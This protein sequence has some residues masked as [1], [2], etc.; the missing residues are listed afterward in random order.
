MLPLF[1]ALFFGSNWRYSC[2]TAEKNF[3]SFY[4][5]KI[6][7]T[8]ESGIPGALETNPTRNHGVVGSIPGL[9]RWVE[10]LAFLWLWCAG[11]S[12]AGWG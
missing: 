5:S 6:Y 1:P 2:I 4:C 10:D 7:V 9:A 8:S 11:A 3:L 12:S